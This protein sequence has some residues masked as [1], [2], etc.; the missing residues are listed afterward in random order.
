MKADY[1]KKLLTEAVVVGTLLVPV[2]VMTHKIIT[3][4]FP[5]M[6]D[7]TQDYVSVAVSGAIFHL[8]AEESGLNDY[9]LDNS[10]AVLKRMEKENVDWTENL[11]DPSL[12]NGSCGW[13]EGGL[14][15]HYSF[16]A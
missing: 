4:M 7:T 2:F 6:K 10:V 1:S 16:H 5:R 11:N 14:C 9:Y 13:Q 12:C 3:L 8:L 15:S